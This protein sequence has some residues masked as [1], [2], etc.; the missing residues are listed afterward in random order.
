MSC[1]PYPIGRGFIHC[2]YFNRDMIWI[3]CPLAKYSDLY[4]GINWRNYRRLRYHKLNQISKHKYVEQ[5]KIQ[6]PKEV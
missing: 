6:L 4:H 1:C 3:D 2:S 5:L